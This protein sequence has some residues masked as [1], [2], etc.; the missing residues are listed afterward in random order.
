[1]T[2]EEMLEELKKPFKKEEVLW[3]LSRKN[4]D[5]TKGAVLAYIDT[6][7]IMQR[8]DEVVGGSNW[9]IKYTP[10]DMG[11][12]TIDTYNG[13]KNNH[14]K[15]FLAEL[16]IF[17][18]DGTSVSKTDGSNCTD[19]ECFKGGLSSA[20]KRVASTYGIGRYLYKLPPTWVDIDNWGNFTPPAIPS[21][22]LPE[23]SNTQISSH[24]GSEDRATEEPPT[25]EYEEEY[26]E[27]EEGPAPSGEVVFKKGKFK[28]KPVS[29]VTDFGYLEWVANKS[30]SFTPEEVSAAKEKLEKIN[31]EQEPA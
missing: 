22:A 17:F 16:T 31:N 1:M 7:A 26:N 3:R 4:K 2:N 8:L 29:S 6:R 20:F 30:T 9:S 18:P 21:W 12:I 25:E 28:G 13:K 11:T 5:K 19:V 15:G 24:H 27:P 10:V 23:G 14:V